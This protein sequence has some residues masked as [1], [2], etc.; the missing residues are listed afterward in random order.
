[1]AV[2][3]RG[4]AAPRVLC[5]VLGPSLRERQ[6]GH[7][8]RPEKGSGA[9]KELENTSHGEQLRDLGLFSLELRGDLSTLCSSLKGGC[10]G[11]WPLL[12]R[13]SSRH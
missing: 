8:S 6:W 1:M 5:S 4:G 7:G 13:N 10:V 12:P 3:G 2:L 9:V 11:C